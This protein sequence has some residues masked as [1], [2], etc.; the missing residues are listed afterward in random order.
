MSLTLAVLLSVALQPDMIVTT[1]WLAEHMNDPGVIVVEIGEKPDFHPGNLE[2][3][4][5]AH[6]PG[7]H[8]LPRSAILLTRDGIP[9]EMPP[10]DAI[11][12]A[13]GRAGIGNE[14]HIVLYSANP[15]LAT[16]AWF[17][18]DYL[19]HGNR[20]SVLDGGIGKWMAEGRRVDPGR[21]GYPVA[22]FTAT[23]DPRKMIS[24]ADM[25][26]A[27]TTGQYLG[28]AALVV[29]ARPPVQY[30]GKKRGSEVA[31][32]GHIPS[33][34]CFPWTAHFTTSSPRVLRDDT[35]LREMY[36]SVGATE[37]TR[38]IVYCRTGVEA[39]MNY[40]VLRHLGFDVVLY[41]GSYVEWSRTSEPIVASAS[42]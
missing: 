20:A 30:I 32:A 34:H 17:T 21:R 1:D 26:T 22:Q 38:L 2:F 19:G 10:I 40:F 25:T 35:A 16:R 29:D 8:F 33:A 27:I 4:R 7:A 15:L 11:E 5:R 18:L 24:K 41:D 31:R 12:S 42:P 23:P 39:S 6:I 37:G 9:D 13:F 14:G 3:D 28:E 36:A